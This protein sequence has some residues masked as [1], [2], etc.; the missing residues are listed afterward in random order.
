[1][2]MILHLLVLLI[3]STNILVLPCQLHQYTGGTVMV[4]PLVLAYSISWSG[5]EWK[6]MF[7]KWQP[8]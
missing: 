2:L 4:A 3:G 1:M 6:Q 5:A 8:N 7:S